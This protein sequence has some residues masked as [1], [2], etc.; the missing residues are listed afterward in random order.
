MHSDVTLKAEDFKT[1][2]NTLWELQYGNA[3]NVDAAVEKIR[4]ALADCYAQ[5]D[6]V[7]QKRNDHFSEVRASLGLEAIWSMYEVEDLGERHAYAGVRSVTYTTHW[8]EGGDVVVPVNGLTWAALYVAANAA[9][10]DSGDAHHVFIEGF[11]QVGDT[12][13]LSTGS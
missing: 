4:A 1:I 5:E 9:I 11:Q 10:R 2:H 3:I 13:V 6:A 8:G 12:L 7:F